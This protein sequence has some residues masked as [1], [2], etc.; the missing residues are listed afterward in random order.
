MS[1]LWACGLGLVRLVAQDGFG[2]PSGAAWPSATGGMSSTGLRAWVMSLMLAAVVMTSRGVPLPSQIRWCLLPVFRRSTGDGPVAA[3][4]VSRGRGSRPRRC[5][6]SRVRRPCSARRAGRGAVTRRRRPSANGPGVTSRSVRS[7][8]PDPG[9]GVA[10]RCPGAGR[11]R[12]PAGTVGRPPA[13]APAPARARAGAAVTPDQGT[14]TRS[15]YE[16]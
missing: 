5:G 12:C 14:S 9:V 8:T 15:C 10:K 1:Q 11:T 16:L 13:L 2:S 7:R 6:S 4:P 3:P